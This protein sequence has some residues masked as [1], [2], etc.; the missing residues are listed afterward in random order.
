MSVSVIAK[1]VA[2]VSLC[3]P[4]LVATPAAAQRVVQ[5]YEAYPQQRSSGD[6]DG[7]FLESLFS[8]SHP[9]PAGY[10]TSDGYNEPSYR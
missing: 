8:D 4:L 2:I 3:S 7:D 1:F 6:Y 9:S 10:N 5:R